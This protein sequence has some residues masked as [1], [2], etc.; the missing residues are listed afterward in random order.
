MSWSGNGS[1][2]PTIFS[3]N[4][5]PSPQAIK[6]WI[7]EKGLTAQM[8][9]SSTSV[10]S[11]PN[12]QWPVLSI[13]RMT[14][15]AGPTSFSRARRAVDKVETAGRFADENVVNCIFNFHWILERAAVRPLNCNTAGRG[16]S[17]LASVVPED[18]DTTSSGG[19]VN[20]LFLSNFSAAAGEI[21][22]RSL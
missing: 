13:F 15:P 17:S 11:A 1:D 10:W 9:S 6:P 8:E 3:P 16:S 5:S 18:T 7:N 14:E 20:L 19:N 22:S 4:T 12:T 21:T 2:T